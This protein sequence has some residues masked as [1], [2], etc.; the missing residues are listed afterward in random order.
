M[1]S[2]HAVI[3]IALLFLLLATVASVTIW[4][5][6]PSPV[7]IGMFAFGFGAGITAGTLI[8]RRRNSVG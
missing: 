4:G 6:A 2:N 5:D 3:I 8:A 1:K 7:K